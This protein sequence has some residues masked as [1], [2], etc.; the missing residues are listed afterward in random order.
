[1]RTLSRNK[2]KMFYSNQLGEI[3]IYEKD[4]DGN[5]KTIEIDGELIPVE[6]GEYE[7]LYSDPV[8]FYGN[9]ALSGGESTNVE[10]GVDISNYDGILIVNK[11]LLDLS[12]TSVIWYKTEIDFDDVNP[13]E[14]DYR[15][16]KVVPSINGDKFLLQ[17]IVK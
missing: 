11:N 5:I 8:E 2:Q 14:A 12:E 17:R 9:I 7:M 1:M 6:T 4:E 15:V 13:N 16:S 10:F 3:P